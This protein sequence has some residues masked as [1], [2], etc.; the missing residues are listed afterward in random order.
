MMLKEIRKKYKKNQLHFLSGVRLSA[1]SLYFIVFFGACVFCFIILFFYFLHFRFLNYF[2]FMLY[3]LLFWFSI[4]CYI[5]IIVVLVV[6]V[7]VII[8][9]FQVCRSVGTVFVLGVSLLIPAQQ[10]AVA[11][12][13]SSCRYSMTFMYMIVL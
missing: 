5:I 12:W 10:L 11:R 1:S 2:R 7:V 9:F 13:F 4:L 3:S 8:T 6:V